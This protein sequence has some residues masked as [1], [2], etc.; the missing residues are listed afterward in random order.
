MRIVKLRKN[1]VVHIIL[2][3]AFVMLLFNFIRT[4]PHDK[5]KHL[6]KYWADS[7]KSIGKVGI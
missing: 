6:N 1:R 3:L 5:V 2:G 7:L 4:I